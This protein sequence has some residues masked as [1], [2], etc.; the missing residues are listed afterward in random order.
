MNDN[1][2]VTGS[3]DGKVRIWDISAQ[4]VVDWTDI[5]DIITAICY[6][7]DGEVCDCILIYLFWEEKKSSA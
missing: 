3:I 4:R 6:R 5:K 7:P 2:F 1:Y